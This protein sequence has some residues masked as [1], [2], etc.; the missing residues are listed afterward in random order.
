M[1]QIEPTA[2]LTVQAVRRETPFEI[3]LGLAGAPATFIDAYR[4]PGMHV[5]VHVNQIEA[6]AILSSRPGAQDLEVLVESGSVL[7]RALAEL[8]PGARL[9]IGPPCGDPVPLFEFRRH[10]IYLMG[11]GAG[12]GLLR[13]AILHVLTERGAFETVRVFAEGTYPHELAY[14]IEFPAWQHA[15]VTV[16]QTLSRPDCGTWRG[17]EGAYVHDFVVNQGLDATRTIVV[18]AGPHDLVQRAMSALRRLGVPPDRLFTFEAG[19][20]RP[21][22]LHAPERPP[23]LLSKLSSEGLWGSG[24]QEDAPDHPP[25]SMR[26]IAQPTGSG[27]PQYKRH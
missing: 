3:H 21:Q 8:S 13:S 23:E 20:T 26:P 27:V 18:V 17:K 16:H 4:G 25:V 7:G 1:S 6:D 11:R 12:L 22:S 24:H 14:R 19:A 15:G 10:H 5:R 9:R 2:E